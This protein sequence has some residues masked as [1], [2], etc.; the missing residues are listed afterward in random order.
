MANEVSE[1]RDYRTSVLG[2]YIT[3]AIYSR[4]PKTSDTIYN[5]VVP[6][7]VAENCDGGETKLDS[8]FEYGYKV[9]DF[10]FDATDLANIRLFASFVADAFFYGLQPLENV[11]FVAE[12]CVKE[13]RSVTVKWGARKKEFSFLRSQPIG[14]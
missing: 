9:P 5:W 8:V 3:M 11:F 7:E 10:V 4:I 12:V 2:C 14:Q 6:G 1:K 13:D